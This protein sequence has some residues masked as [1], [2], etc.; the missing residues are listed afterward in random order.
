M[1][2]VAL[3]VALVVSLV[4]AV[5]LAARMI[6]FAMYSE[7]L[8]IEHM[9]GTRSVALDP[10]YE[11]FVTPG[12]IYTPDYTQEIKRLRARLACREV[13]LGP[14]HLGLAPVLLQLAQAAYQRTLFGFK[15]RLRTAEG[16][17]RRALAIYE[18]H[19]PPDAPELA[20]IHLSLGKMYWLSLRPLS[21]MNH[22]DQALALRTAR[23]GDNHPL[24]RPIL[25]AMATIHWR[26]NNL[27]AAKAL[28]V[29]SLEIA[30][31]TYG[32][33]HPEILRPLQGLAYIYNQQR[34]FAE[35]EVLYRRMFELEPDLLRV[36]GLARAIAAQGRFEEAEALLRE[37]L[38]SAFILHDAH[39]ECA[40]RAIKWQLAEIAERDGRVEDAE[41]IYNE[42][43][44]QALSKVSQAM[45]DNA[46]SR[47]VFMYSKLERDEDID[48]LRR[49]IKAQITSSRP[50]AYQDMLQRFDSIFEGAR[51]R[52]Q[53]AR[54][55]EAAE[56]Q[57]DN[58]SP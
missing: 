13:L 33:H 38:D 39:A 3:V 5:A 53:R 16:S 35:V 7:A 8:A 15:Y 27:E 31:E 23:E 50:G 58:T 9:K 6:T 45:L 29:R 24:L 47:L 46:V 21:A 22:L 34:R 51:R 20:D 48:V 11:E 56:A 49:E 41:A 36:Q 40:A 18:K 25:H 44:E 10:R 55:R 43:I 12:Q 19:L 17:Y 52:G 32:A 1:R 26:R 14:D 37:G 28:Y 42:A 2:Y 30:E 4:V 54:E 57:S